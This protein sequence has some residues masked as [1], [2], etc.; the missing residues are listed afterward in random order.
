LRIVADRIRDVLKFGTGAARRGLRRQAGR[1]LVL[2]Y[3]NVRPDHERARGER[4]LHVSRSA[5]CRQLDFLQAHCDVVPLVDV[6]PGATARARPRVAITLDDG[7][8][9]ALT[10]GLE[11]LTRRSLPATYFVIPGRLGHEFWWDRLAD[12]L[13]GS[14]PA[15][16]RPQVLDSLRGEESLIAAWAA[17]RGIRLAADLPDWA[18]AG[19]LDLV[20]HAYG[21]TGITLGAHTWTHPNLAALTPERM[22]DELER[23]RAWLGERFPRFLPW[24]SFPYGRHSEVVVRVAGNAGYAGCVAIGQQVVWIERAEP[25]AP[26]VVPR[27]D[28]PSTWSLARFALRVADA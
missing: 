3:H 22:A 1:S 14:I 9:G 5:F 17:E 16:A 6:L 15:D 18:R 13:G 21:A 4:G 2:A 19:S 12:P 10:I 8:V 24:L 27:L 11:E 26:S 20:T 28:V 7:Y 23:S 25:R